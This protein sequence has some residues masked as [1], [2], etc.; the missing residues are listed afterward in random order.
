MKQLA[1]LTLL[2]AFSVAA[3]EPSDSVKWVGPGKIQ[4]KSTVIASDGC[5]SAGTATKGHPEG[6]TPVENAILITY[7]L[8]HRDGMCTM[9]L[10]PVEFTITSDV[11]ADAKAVVIY[12]TD[13]SKKS[14][15]ARALALPRTKK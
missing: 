1:T 9:A 2:I 8:E 5:Y 10:K 6:A 15:I 13:K 4:I 7:P 14:M 11:P 12:T 3:Q